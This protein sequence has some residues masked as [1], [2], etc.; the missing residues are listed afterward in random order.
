M[1]IYKL[2][3]QLDRVVLRLNL[4]LYLGAYAFFVFLFLLLVLTFRKIPVC[5]DGGK[6]SPLPQIV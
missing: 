2:L 5:R 6:A 4:I 1:G 3:D